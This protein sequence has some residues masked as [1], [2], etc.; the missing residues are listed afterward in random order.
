MSRWFLLSLL[1]LI[2]D[3]VSKVTVASSM[4]LYESIAL[5][6]SFQLTYVH[7]PGA[8]FSFL[9]D[10]G[11]WQRWFFIALSSVVSV[12]IS[13]WLVRLPAALRWQATG[14][15]LVLGGAVGNLVD[16]VL[17][18]YVIDF[19]DVYY[20][21]WHWPA[22]NVADAAITIGAVILLVD[23]FRNPDSLLQELK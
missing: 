11:G 5:V 18:G 6:P 20:R 1:V 17:Y 14:L 19:L 13:I 8:A 16:R 2:V 23:S 3:Q 22:F 21:S 15:A 10:A 9:S 12:L 4:H 7:N